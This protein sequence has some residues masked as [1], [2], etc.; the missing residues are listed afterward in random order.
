MPDHFHGIVIIDNALNVKNEKGKDPFTL[1]DIIGKFKSY[2]SRK[3]RNLLG[4]KNKFDWQTSFYDRII[5][6]DKELYNIRKYIQENPLRWDI[7]KNNPENL[8]M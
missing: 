8:E 4:N 2:S 5:R 7:E 6:N 1:S 3:I